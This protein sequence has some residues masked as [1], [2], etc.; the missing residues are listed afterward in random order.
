MNSLNGFWKEDKG[1]AAGYVLAYLGHAVLVQRWGFREQY[2]ISTERLI[3]VF[4]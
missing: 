4:A 2:Y 3:Q 1:I